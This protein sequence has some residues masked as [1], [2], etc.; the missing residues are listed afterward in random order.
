MITLK[1]AAG[2]DEGTHHSLR[3]HRKCSGAWRSRARGPGSAD[4]RELNVATVLPPPGNRRAHQPKFPPDPGP[5]Y[6]ADIANAGIAA[7]YGWLMSTGNSLCDDWA[8][9][10]TT[11]QT[12]PILTAGGIYAYH[13]VTFDGR[14]LEIFG[15]EVRRFHVSL[16]SVTVP[17]PDKRGGRNVTLTQASR[18]SFLPLDEAAFER[19]QPV[20]AAIASAGVTITG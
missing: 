15:G 13:L 4:S 6:A 9:G 18:D 17:R 11:A 7:P 2:S 10:E 3:G 5:A 14:I 1:G 19:C 16:L 8:A 12:D 20:F